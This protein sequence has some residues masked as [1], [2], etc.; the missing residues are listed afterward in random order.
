MYC[1]H[2]HVRGGDESGERRAANSTSGMCVKACS[3]RAK[4]NANVETN[5]FIHICHFFYFKFDFELA[6]TLGF[7]RSVALNVNIPKSLM[8]LNDREYDVTDM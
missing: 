6:G 7:P 2:H 1:A 4:A 5:F 3:H 8:I